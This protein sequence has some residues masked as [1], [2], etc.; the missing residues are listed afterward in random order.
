M[1][2]ILYTTA[3]HYNPLQPDVDNGAAGHHRA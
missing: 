2:Q 3:T 1:H